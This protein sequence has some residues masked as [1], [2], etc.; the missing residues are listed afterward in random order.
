MNSTKQ[1][2]R[3]ILTDTAGYI[4]ILAAL[5]T[6]W[7]PGPGG[8]PLLVAGL[9]LLSIHNAWAKRLREYVLH[10]GSELV[11]RLF[12]DYALVQV[13]YDIVVTLALV[14]AAVLLWLHHEYWQL[15]LAGVLVGLGLA[16]GLL[17]RRRYE[18]IT[19][20]MKHKL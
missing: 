18:R 3:R 16:I 15:A 4:L 14:L 10:H 9:G 20:R 5:A 1:K 12:P 6:G 8:I 2:L 17:N 19:Q 7:L 11:H 13:L